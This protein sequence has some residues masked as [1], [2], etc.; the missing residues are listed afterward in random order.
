MTQD[1]MSRAEPSLTD[2][3]AA[4]TEQN[5]P[6]QDV[7]VRDLDKI[8]QCLQQDEWI[9]SVDRN[10][11]LVYTTATGT[12][13]SFRIVLDLKEEDHIL[14]VY[15]FSPVRVPTNKRLD[16]AEFITRANFGT[17]IGNFEMD[18]SDGDLRYKGSFEYDGGELVHKMIEQLLGKCAYSMNK[19]FPGLMRIIYGDVDPRAAIAEIEPSQSSGD[20]GAAIATA[21]LEALAAGNVGTTNGDNGASDES[22]TDTPIVVATPSPLE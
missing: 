7:Q 2:T 11:P 6:T 13:G 14:I 22:S 17:M 21:L 4:T 3:T 1:T 20:A 5:E 9:Y 19:Y 18:F 15:V 12:N 10:R 8:I 16:V